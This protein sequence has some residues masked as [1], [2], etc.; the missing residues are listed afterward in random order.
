MAECSISAL[1]LFSPKPTQIAVESG[2]HVKYS[3]IASIGDGPIKVHYHSDF[4]SF[5]DPSQT[6]IEVRCKIIQGDGSNVPANGQGDAAIGQPSTC[7]LTLQSLWSQVDVELNGKVISSSTNTYAYRSIMETILSYGVDAQD[8]WLRAAGFTRETSTGGG[9]EPQTR[10]ETKIQVSDVIKRSADMFAQSQEV[11]LIGRLHTDI[12]SQP[13]YL[14]PGVNIDLRFIKQRDE[15]IIMKEKDDERTYKMKILDLNVHFRKVSVTDEMKVHIE[16]QIQVAP[17]Q[18][19]ISR[20]EMVKYTIPQGVSSYEADNL[21]NGQLPT[22]IIF[23]LVKDASV[24]GSMTSNPFNFQGLS[25]SEASLSVN[26]QF[27]PHAPLKLNLNRAAAATPGFFSLFA[28]SGNL[29]GNGGPSLTPYS[30]L[31]AGNTLYGF[32]LSP[33]QTSDCVG[34]SKRGNI[35]LALRFA[36]ATAEA[37]R[38]IV[39]IQYDNII[40]IDKNRAVLTDF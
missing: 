3:P 15:F 25:L 21:I 26:S 5:I 18:Y 23:G 11:V 20:V 4:N 31:N 2:E 24:N 1:D 6:I 37:I 27:I 8:S 14:P 34:E 40:H 35:K 17:M 12:T 38:V 28:A 29:F 22:K 7:N 32:D 19:P 30:W 39:Y 13:R 9:V 36:S 10:A 16:K 33:H